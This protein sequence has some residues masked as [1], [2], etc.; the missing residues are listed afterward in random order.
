[1]VELLAGII[2]FY[3][4][5][6]FVVVPLLAGIV[7]IFEEIFKGVGLVKSDDERMKEFIKSQIDK[8]QEEN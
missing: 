7:C 2:V 4:L 3:L 5:A 6:V 8:T 1:M